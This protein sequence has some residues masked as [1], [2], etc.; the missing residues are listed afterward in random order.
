MNKVVVVL[1]ALYRYQ[2]VSPRILHPILEKIEGVEPYTI[3]FKNRET[4]I[5]DAPTPREEELFVKT[6]TD[7]NPSIVGFTVLSPYVSIA[8]RLSALV[9]KNTQAKVIWGG[10]HP[11]I[12]PENCINDADMLCIGEG[13]GAISDLA[14]S[15][16][17]G[18]P[19]DSI[20]NLWV[21]EGKHIVKNPLRPLIQDLDSLPFPSYKNKSY[22]FIDYNRVSNVDP[23]PSYSLF[24]V[25]AS[26]GC[27]YGCSYCC[28]SLLWPLYKGLGPYI[29]RRSV[30]NILKE[31]K[32]NNKSG[33]IAFSDEVF[34]TD[35]SWLDEFE[36]RYKDEIGLPF[37]VEYHPND[38][39]SMIIKKLVSAGVEII[40]FGMQAGSD[41]VRQK[42]YHR[43]EKN[44]HII[45]ISKEIAA[46]GIR[47][48]HD[49]IIDNPYDTVASLKET[50]DLLL[51]LPK[52]LFFNLYSLQYF[53]LYPVTTMAIRD[54][55]IKPDESSVDRLLERTTMNWSFIPKFPHSEKQ[56][57]QNVIWIYVRRHAKDSSVKY[58][59]FGQSLGSRLCLTYLNFKSILYGMILEHGGL[60]W[61]NRWLAYFGNALG[62][63][64]RGE[65]GTLYKKTKKRIK[66]I[67]G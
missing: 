23:V 35:E 11:T 65:W 63:F 57:L 5:F 3:F 66:A 16:R 56:K 20:N 1:V 30:D 22:Y 45:K 47:I 53:P 38:I 14:K 55:F 21:R 67:R 37:Y 6:L 42:I 48:K 19:Y 60:V 17:D 8:R 59:V 43:P 18:K 50:I 7:L 13:E 29:R 40:N 52:P 64:F 32:E 36:K 31:I 62:H 28:N 39:N 49:L 15:M 26:R 51:Q 33:Y 34:G 41:S 4:N 54:G 2:V 24:W 44:A 25:K 46:H 61:R 12:F 27:P 9:K 10:I 58:A